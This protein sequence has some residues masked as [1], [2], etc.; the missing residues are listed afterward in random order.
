MPHKPYKTLYSTQ[1]SSLTMSAPIL[2]LSSINVLCKACG[3][4]LW[5]T[6][7]PDCKNKHTNENHHTEKAKQTKTKT[8]QNK[9]KNQISSL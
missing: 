2:F 6:L 3:V 5:Y 4:T 9:K 7:T 1:N 8:K